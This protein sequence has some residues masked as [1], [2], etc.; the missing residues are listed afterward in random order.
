MAVPSRSVI[1]PPDSRNRELAAKSCTASSQA[2]SCIYGWPPVEMLR[3][4][5]GAAAATVP[6]VGKN[7][8]WTRFNG[9]L[10]SIEQVAQKQRDRWHV[11]DDHQAG[12]HHQHERK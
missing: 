1:T 7:E 10:L 12:E 2:L 8:S 11:G 5:N 6:A 4:S 9:D 3:H